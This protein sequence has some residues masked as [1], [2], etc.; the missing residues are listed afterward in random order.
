MTR[1]HG[2]VVA[3][4]GAASGIG[5]ALARRL[6]EAGARLAL[7]DRDQAGVEAVARACR[8]AR[9]YSVDVADAAAVS[10]WADQ[11]VA[12]FGGADVIINNAGVALT[13]DIVDLSLDDLHEIMAV[14]FWGVVHGTKAFLPHLIAGGGGHVVNVSSVFG[15][16]GVASQSAYNAAKFAVRGFTEALRQEMK[17]AGHP[18]GVTCVV[19]GGVRTNVMRNAR[20]V[21]GY[22]HADLIVRFDR[23]LARTTPERAAELI[24]H[25]IERDRSRVLVGT[26]AHALDLA[27]RV[28]GPAYQRLAVRVLRSRR[29]LLVRR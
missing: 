21:G 1:V 18:V 17:L 15:L 9:A 7:A 6:D 23:E 28:L 29:G 20:V 10:A 11:V 22:D 5:L 13:G 14:D 12:D 16:V 25:G 27:V 4:T 19:P 26:D 24:V 2:K 3:I 8:Q